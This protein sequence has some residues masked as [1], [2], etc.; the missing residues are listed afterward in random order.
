MSVV[1]AP[2]IL[3]KQPLEVRKYTMSFATLL[4]TDE[5]ILSITSVTHTLRGGS[6]SD[7]TVYNEV[8]VGGTVEF[9]V[10]GGTDGNTYRLEILIVTDAGQT[11]EGDGLI[12]VKDK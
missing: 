10:S 2:E 12:S 7:L 4:A 6:V 5:G 9:W 8:V 3:I 1:T 11:L